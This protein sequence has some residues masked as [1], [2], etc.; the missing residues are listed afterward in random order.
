[1]VKFVV[2]YFLLLIS[3]NNLAQNKFIPFFNQSSSA[4]KLVSWS[5]GE[6]SF[7]T[8]LVNK[9]GFILTGG[10]LQPTI[11]NSSGGT[12]TNGIDLKVIIG[13]NPIRDYLTI[14]C[15]QLGVVITGIQVA[16][17]F[18]QTKII[19]KG[20]FSGVNFKTQ[21]PFASVNTGV[22]F[23]SIYYIVDQQFTKIKVYK[24]I[25]A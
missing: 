4:N 20:P 16:D 6:T 1:M 21:L 2:I 22:Y 10:F 5:L 23:I 17:V 14:I 11:I 9:N 7:T 18:G 12:S 19:F 15:H 8:T 25:K 13:P 3:N 24:V